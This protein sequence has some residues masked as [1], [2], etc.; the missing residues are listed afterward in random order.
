M[1]LGIAASLIASV[2]FFVL[3]YGVSRARL[4]DYAPAI[5]AGW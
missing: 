3:G 2:I 5:V 4:W 1:V